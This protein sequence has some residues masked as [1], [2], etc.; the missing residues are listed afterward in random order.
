MVTVDAL[1]TDRPRAITE[2]D[3]S[4]YFVRS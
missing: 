1:N 3:I 4:K 2:R